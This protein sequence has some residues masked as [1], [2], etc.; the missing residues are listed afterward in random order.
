MMLIGG[1]VALAIGTYTF[2]WLGPALRS[3]IQFP[4]RAKRLLEVG[5]TVLLAALVAVET[6]PFTEGHV[7]AALPAG[8]L[9]AGI[10]A[11]R[12]CPLLVVILAAAA[13]TAGLRLLGLA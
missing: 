8:V 2:R 12:R 9:V 6:L 4:E 13:T 1:I 3:R 10:L 5:A 7:G 11:W